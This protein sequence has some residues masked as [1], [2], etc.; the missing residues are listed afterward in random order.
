[1]EEVTIENFRCF[2]DRQ[3]ARLAPLT[4][5]VG[6]NS[7]GKTSLMAMTRILGHAV[8]QRETRPNFRQ[9]PFDLGSIRDIVHQT[10]GDGHRSQEFSGG[11]AFDDTKIEATFCQGKIS[12][13]VCRLHI[14]NSSTSATWSRS[15]DD[16]VELEVRTSRGR[17]KFDSDELESQ[18]LDFGTTPRSDFWG[19]LS[20][21]GLLKDGRLKNPDLA[22]PE[23]RDEVELRKLVLSPFLYVENTAVPRKSD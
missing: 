6:E 11:F 13:E 12:V 1:M 18:E 4:F 14:K 19:L 2:R 17:W 8:M 7:T 5:L 22:P 20:L 3:T 9:A 16:H 21:S 15:P 23:L 10:N